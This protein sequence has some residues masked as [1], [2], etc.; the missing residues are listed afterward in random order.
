MTTRRRP[1]TTRQRRTILRALA[2]AP[3][4]VSAQTLH[5]RLQQA[6]E[7]VGLTTV[8]R[9]LHAYAETGQVI[10]TNTD[11]ASLFRLVPGPAGTHYLICR[12]CGDS[13]PVDA[14]PVQDWAVTTASAHG[15]TGIHLV[16][17]LT[18]RC[19][20]CTGIPL[21]AAGQQQC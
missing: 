11:G 19:P 4:F 17:E 21:T 6:G 20:V 2:Q 15:F 9:A 1:C 7:T 13:F 5:A 16:L 12:T 10:L 8:Y 3:G 14:Q 18:G